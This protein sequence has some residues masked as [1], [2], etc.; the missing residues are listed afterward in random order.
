[1][2]VPFLRVDQARPVLV[3]LPGKAKPGKDGRK[4]VTPHRR[5]SKLPGTPAANREHHEVRALR[6]P[7]ITRIGLPGAEMQQ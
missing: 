6:S 5:T 4:S 2:M 7:T 1:M 3:V